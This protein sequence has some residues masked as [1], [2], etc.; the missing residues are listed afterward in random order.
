MSLEI[1]KNQL[2]KQLS[3]VLMLGFIGLFLLRDVSG[4]SVNKFIFVAIAAVVFFIQD[5]D[6]MYQWIALMLPY[7]NGLPGTYIMCVAIVLFC[8]KQYRQ[9]VLHKIGLFVCVSILSIELSS[10]VWGYFNVLDYLRFAGVFL[11]TFFFAFDG[12]DNYQYDK[13]VRNFI[14]GTLIAIANLVGQSLKV[15]TLSEFFLSGVRFGNIKK[16]FNITQEGILLSYNEN[17]LAMLCAISLMMCVLMLRKTG[18]KWYL[19]CGVV[20]GLAGVMTQSRTYLVVVALGTVM[21]IYCNIQTI[22]QFFSTIFTLILGSGICLLIIQVV[23]PVYIESLLL[24]FQADD[25]SNGRIEIFKMFFDAQMAKP[26]SI[27]FGVGLQS[28]AEKLDL[29]EAAHM[30]LQQITITWGVIG[31]CL[32]FLLFFTIVYQLNYKT[33][34]EY[35]YVIP[36]FMMLIFVQAVQLFTMSEYILYFIALFACAKLGAAHEKAHLSDSAG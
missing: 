31:L 34:R 30:A 22:Q 5:K 24:R 6:H 33:K 26:K 9:L 11:A 7:I 3:F 20:I 29:S 36:Y 25:L 15:Y 12:K 27:F 19:V 28:Y 17:S 21:Y 32:V 8:F 4:V 2:S 13:I 16:Q 35:I 14:L 23:I 10:M 1:S 18:K